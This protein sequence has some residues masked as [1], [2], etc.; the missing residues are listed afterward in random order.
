MGPNFYTIQ[1]DETSVTTDFRTHPKYA[2]RIYYAFAPIWWAM[3]IWDM[4]FADV[5]APALSFGFYSLTV[6]P[7]PD[8][9]VTTC[10]GNV[11]MTG[12]SI[13][14][15]SLLASAGNGSDTASTS[16]NIFRLHSTAVSA[17]W[18]GYYKA[19]ML[20]NTGP[21]LARYTVSAATLSV[22]NPGSGGTNFGG[23]LCLVSS[24]P[25]SNTTLASSDF[26]TSHFG[27]TE[28]ATSITVATYFATTL[29]YI[30]F[31]LNASGRT[32]ITKG[33]IT[34][35]GWV[36]GWDLGDV[37]PTW[38]GSSNSTIQCAYADTSGTSNDPKLVVTY[39]GPNPFFSN[40]L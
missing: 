22:W 5:F 1:K 37:A 4:M 13:A 9:G 32:N 18:E 6:Y 21:V 8:P 33:G 28:L 16:A 29:Q 20:F 19:M 40:F 34:K 35:F 23:R 11:F 30:D 24:S 27:S 12:Q 17:Q 14:F 39:S 10:D 31:V 7:D 15:A 38:A 36:S 2:K 3:H 26:A 25:A